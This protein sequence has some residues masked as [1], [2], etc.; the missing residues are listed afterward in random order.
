MLYWPRKLEAKAMTL[1]LSAPT[2]LMF[3]VAVAIA[4]LAALTALGA[5]SI[6]PIPSVWIMGIAFLVLAVGCLFKGA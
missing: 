6:L 5:I 3:V 4:V 2:T 1:K